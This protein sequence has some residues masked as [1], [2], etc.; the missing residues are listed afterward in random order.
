[1]HA[2][3]ARWLGDTTAEDAGR[4]TLNPLR[5][6][7]PF[8]TVLLPIISIWQF[9]ALF[10]AAKPVPFNPERVRFGEFGAA[11]VGIAGPFTNLAL[12]IIGSVIL[13]L[14]NTSID[15]GLL[16]ALVI[17]I[18][19]NVSLFVFN[20]IPFPPLDGSRLLYAVA[21]DPLQELMGR[22]EAMG[23]T[24]III[25]MLLF[26]TFLSPIFSNIVNSVLSFLLR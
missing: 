8:T 15:F 17:F 12:A 26:F 21:P 10:L 16:N 23:F 4:L 9:H 14:S 3:T 18:E 11:L 6:I 13:R 1:M 19:V 25:F 5:H 22:I 20:M 7:D 2:F 24:A